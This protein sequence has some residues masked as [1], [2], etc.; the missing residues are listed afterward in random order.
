MKNVVLIGPPGA[1]K[2]SCGKILAD[3]LSCAFYDTDNLIE[4]QSG[5][6]VKDIFGQDGE[7]HFRY[8]ECQLL[9]AL[10]EHPD[11]ALGSS[12]SFILATGGGMPVKAGNLAK[13]NMIGSVVLLD[14]SLDALVLRVSQTG[15][16]RPLLSD[17][18]EKDPQV[19]TRIRLTE[20]LA[21]RKSIYQQAGYKIDTTALS[22]ADTAKRVIDVLGL[23]GSQIRA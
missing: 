7:E 9:D 8:L 20:L 5:K 10:I 3:Y 15:P 2:T 16:N 4:A 1:G 12:D 19:A 6:S 22:P 17:G 18:S 13:L 14:A 23:D 21:S 11:K